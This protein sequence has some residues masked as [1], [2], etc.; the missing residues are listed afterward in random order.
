MNTNQ[1]HATV[2]LLG[3][4]SMAAEA[5]QIRLA[6]GTVYE[7][8]LAAPVTVVVKTADGDKHVPFAQLPPELQAVYWT[9]IEP[10]PAAVGPVTNDEIAAIAASVNLKT[11]AQVT[12]FGSFRDRPEKRGP[13]GLVVTKAFNAIE[14][15]WAGVYSEEHALAGVRHWQDAL[16]R[17]K[18]MLARP[19][20]HLQ[21][22]WLE[23]F[24]AAAEALGKKDSAEFS[25]RVRA[26]KASPLAPDAFSLA[27][28]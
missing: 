22:R 15:N 27:G 5:D 1:Y 19:V 21:K 6:N 11:W 24:A 13:G 2:V 10:V 7:G 28:M 8:E 3:I 14:D 17:A 23:E 16:M 4:I 26:L 12:A 18:A 25:R 20:Q 9:K